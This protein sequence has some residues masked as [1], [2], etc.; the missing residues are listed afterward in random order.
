MNFN[1]INDDNSLHQVMNM[2]K[3]LQDGDQV[4]IKQVGGKATLVKQGDKTFFQK[5]KSYFYKPKTERLN[6]VADF[7]IALFNKNSNYTQTHLEES[8]DAVNHAMAIL[9]KNKKIKDQFLKVSSSLIHQVPNAQQA[10]AQAQADYQLEVAKGKQKGAN[11]IKQAQEE[12]VSKREELISEGE[13]Q[14]QAILDVGQAELQEIE[15]Q[16]KKVQSDIEELN[17]TA[18]ELEDHVEKFYDVILKTSDGTEIPAESS[19]F[20]EIEYFKS[21]AA[22]RYSRKEASDV[23]KWSH[24]NAKYEIE[25]FQDYSTETVKALIRFIMADSTERSSVLDKMDKESILELYH[26]SKMIGFEDLS[27]KCLEGPLKFAD[28]AEKVDLDHALWV[29]TTEPTFAVDDI[30]I[31]SALKRIAPKFIEISQKAESVAIQHPYLIELIKRDDLVPR[32]EKT[33]FSNIKAWANARTLDP[34]KSED[35]N[36]V[37]IREIL[38]H[39]IG[40]DRLIDHI[41]FEHFSEESFLDA[42]KDGYLSEDFVT[43]SRRKARGNE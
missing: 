41:R 40:D 19:L 20:K 36:K 30:L 32:N 3:G 42:K 13:E 4:E 10:Y 35:D 11:I 2:L 26:L 25:V 27:K 34:K 16:K 18:K 37:E 21:W 8:L 33:L 38:Y 1:P 23:Q 5:I 15:E 43:T 28:T 39:Q 7:T 29:L 17:K 12:G 31:Q 6:N 14:K 22:G 9:G 24:P